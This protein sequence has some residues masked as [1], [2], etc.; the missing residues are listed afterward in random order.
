MACSK[1]K[2]SDSGPVFNIEGLI[3]INNLNDLFLDTI[4]ALPFLCSGADEFITTKVSSK[5]VTS[6]SPIYF[7]IPYIYSA[8]D[9]I[10]Y[11]KYTSTTVKEDNE[12]ITTYIVPYK[13]ELKEET[14][15]ITTIYNE[16]SKILFFQIPREFSY[17]SKDEGSIAIYNSMDNNYKGKILIPDSF[18]L[19]DLIKKINNNKKI[20]INFNISSETNTSL[21][22]TNYSKITADC[23]GCGCCA[24]L[25]T[26]CIICDNISAYCCCNG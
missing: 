2:C 9:N 13:S 7:Q 23:F 20:T 15:T 14:I 16:I 10:Y 24:C 26:S 3:S 4:Y 18:L 22:N 6:R 1:S 8:A 11:G 12:I 17:N 25:I 21:T 19:Y 5:F